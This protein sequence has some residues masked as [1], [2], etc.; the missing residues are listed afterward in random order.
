MVNV[1]YVKE[2]NVCTHERPTADRR[3][4]GGCL[5]PSVNVGGRLPITLVAVV[6]FTRDATPVLTI[7]V[8]TPH[9]ICLY[10]HNRTIRRRTIAGDAK[11]RSRATSAH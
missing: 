7:S 5:Q 6:A 1:V 8:L 10:H 11:C 9:A 3:Y 2:P 4:N